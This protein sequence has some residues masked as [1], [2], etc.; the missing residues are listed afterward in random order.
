MNGKSQPDVIVVLGAALTPDGDLGPA[1]AER[2]RAGVDAFK[3]GAAPWMMMSGVYE[4][5]KM[6]ARAV[7]LG[8]PAERVIVESTATT[9]HENA[10]RCAELMRERQLRHALV[11]TQRYHRPRSIAA[12]RRAGVEATAFEFRGQ[13]A[14]PKRLARELIALAIYKLRGWI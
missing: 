6:K 12:F 13:K 8:V 7:A 5:V 10:V 11:V 2:V 1:L 14:K 3:R 4:A 9:T